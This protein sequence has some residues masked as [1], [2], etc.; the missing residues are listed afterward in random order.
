[1]SENPDVEIADAKVDTGL[2]TLKPLYAKS[3]AKS[4]TLFE[5]AEGRRI[6]IGDWKGT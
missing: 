3:I 2:R 4:Y 6:I 1:M 5:S